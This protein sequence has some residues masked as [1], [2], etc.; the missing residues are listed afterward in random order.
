[1]IVEGRGNVEAIKNRVAQIRKEMAVTD[2]DYDKEKLQE[3]LAKLSGGVAF[4]KV[5][6]ATETEMKE[7]KDRIEDALNA[8]RAA[9]A[10]GVVAGGGLALAQ[11]GDAFNELTDKK[12]DTPGARLVD[13]A[14]LEP[15]KQIA[16]NAGKDGSL[17]LYNIIKEYQ[18]GNKNL[19]YNAMTDKFEDMFTAGIVDPTK[20][21]RSA[22]EHAASAAIMFLTTEAVIADKPEK[23]DDHGHGGMP[24]GMGG[25]DPSMMGM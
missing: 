19:G 7:K 8:T 10:E 16:A 25:M 6:A 23:K 9:V 12:E 5:G 1:M 3:R 2:S 14:I 4:I 20:V 22:L 11:A 17:I 24:G 15:I 21:V 13:A 18:A